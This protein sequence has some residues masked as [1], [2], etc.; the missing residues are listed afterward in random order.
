MAILDPRQMKTIE[1]YKSSTSPTFSN[2]TQSAI[3]AGYDEKYANN[4]SHT[5]P[6][7]LTSNLVQDV[8]RIVKAEKN[9]DKIIH[10]EIEYTN[11]NIDLIKEQLDN[12]RFVLKT[13]ARA[14]YA[15]DKTPPPASITL[16]ITQYN[17]ADVKPSVIDVEPN[18]ASLD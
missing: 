12:T 9:L 3:Q 5:R 4:L 2:L 18:S 17:N 15:E 11:D 7:W 8:K 14:K 16:N 13:Q 6:E 10:Q 1:N